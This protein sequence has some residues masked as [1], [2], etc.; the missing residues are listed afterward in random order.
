MLF[1]LLW[2][3]AW[4][5]YTCKF[6]CMVAAATYYF[7]SDASKEGEAEVK[8]GF[9]FAYFNHMGSLA[10]GSFVIAVV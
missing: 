8:L 7:N 5:K 3:M 1:V 2:L 6:I 10:V 4:I 9:E